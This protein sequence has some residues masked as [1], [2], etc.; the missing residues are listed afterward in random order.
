MGILEQQLQQMKA[1][2]QLNQEKLEYNFQVL[3]KRDEENMITKAQQKRK[4]TKMQDMSNNLRIKL[5]KQVQAYKDENQHLTD[6]Y[7]RIAQQYKELHKKMR[8]FSQIDWKRFEEI[9]L[10]NEAVA[11]KLVENTLL[12]DRV[13]HEQQLG[14]RWVEPEMK[15][16]DN[17]GPLT[18]AEMGPEKSASEYVQEVI[19]GNTSSEKLDFQWRPQNESSRSS[20]TKEVF[21]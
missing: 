9:W 1:T 16:L 14:L 5:A 3:K 13:I 15:F 8:H 4:I 11:R 7:H 21:S 6:E 2:Y 19:S 17:V 20:A 10:M 18:K 12:A